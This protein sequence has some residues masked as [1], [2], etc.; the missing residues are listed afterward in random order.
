M[1]R[2]GQT[3]H[4]WGH[5]RGFCLCLSTTNSLLRCFLFFDVCYLIS[6]VAL[7]TMA[8]TSEV[9]TGRDRLIMYGGIFGVFASVSALCNSLASHGL[10]TWRRVFLLPWLVF[11]LIVLGLLTVHLAHS[12]YF[13][14]AQW[15]HVFLFLAN[16]TVFTCWR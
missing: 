1:G 3:H 2:Q 10:R 11:F 15:R 13:Y 14:R 9:D 8:L 4:V 5:L 6:G 12:V 7:I 16:I